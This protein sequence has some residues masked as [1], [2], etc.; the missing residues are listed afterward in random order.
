MGKTFD[1][2]KYNRVFYPVCNEK[3]KLTKNPR[4]F[5]VCRKR[6]GFGLVK[7][8]LEENMNTSPII[9]GEEGS[10]HEGRGYL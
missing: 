10:P 1:F 6:G 7:R 3:G 5:D 2:E 8:E 9:G 4:D